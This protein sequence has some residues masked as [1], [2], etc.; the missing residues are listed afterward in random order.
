M[1]IYIWM[2]C[3]LEYSE[4]LC[5]LDLPCCCYCLTTFFFI[6]KLTSFFLFQLCGPCIVIN[7]I[8]SYSTMLI[9]SPFPI[10]PAI[11]STWNFSSLSSGTFFSMISLLFPPPYPGTAVHLPFIIP[12]DLGARLWGIM[13]WATMASNNLKTNKLYQKAVLGAPHQYQLLTSSPSSPACLQLR[14]GISW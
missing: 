8:S 1:V 11:F 12:L 5:E 10:T 6:S 13:Y 4:L 14:S 9:F 7:W 3:F 2:N